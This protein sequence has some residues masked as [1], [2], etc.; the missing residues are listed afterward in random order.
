M[1]PA[2]CYPIVTAELDSQGYE[3]CVPDVTG[4]VAAFAPDQQ[5]LEPT[6]VDPF[7]QNVLNQVTPVRVAPVKLA[8]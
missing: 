5:G 6:L 7:G 1:K 2:N 3:E 4:S 8:L